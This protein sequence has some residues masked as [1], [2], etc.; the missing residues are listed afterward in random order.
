METLLALSIAASAAIFFGSFLIPQMKFYY[1]YDC[2]SQARTMCR[3]AYIKLE[4]TL[5]YGYMYAYDPAGPGEIFY[6]TREDGPK[7]LEE[8]ADKWNEIPAFKTWPSLTAGDLDVRTFGSMSLELDFSGTVPRGVKV[9]IRV[10]REG[11]MIYEQE[12]SI[13]SLYWYD[14]S[15]GS[16]L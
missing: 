14:I 11:D 12:A 7:S 10:V 8:R 3:Q 5:R 13:E 2:M 9:K 15:E 16:A 1:D 6:F 4:E